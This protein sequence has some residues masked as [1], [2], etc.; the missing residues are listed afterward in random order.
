MRRITLV[1]QL[2]TASETRV[3]GNDRAIVGTMY[4]SS[5]LSRWYVVKNHVSV[6][7]GRLEP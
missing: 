7:D 1:A 5:Q 3:R 6:E 4:K 2:K